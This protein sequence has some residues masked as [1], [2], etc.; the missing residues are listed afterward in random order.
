MKLSKSN[1]AGMILTTAATLFITGCDD[2]SI[3]NNDATISYINA[4]DEQATFYVKKSSVSASV[5]DNKH[6]TVSLM[7]GDS[8]DNIRHKWFG[9]EMSRFAAEDT[10]SRDEQVSIKELLKDDRDYWLVAWLNGRDYK[11]SLLR[12]SSSDRDG[13]YRVRIFANDKLD[14]YLDGSDSKFLTTKVGYVTDYFSVEKCSGLVIE[15]NEIDLCT[16]DFGRSY[17][18]VVDDNG[19]ISLVEERR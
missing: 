7:R 2:D 11:L 5:Y 19:L 13:I 6:K 18:A 4:L 1:M 10:N 14:I 3:T 8:S 12:K 9:L 15:D 16:G 17:L